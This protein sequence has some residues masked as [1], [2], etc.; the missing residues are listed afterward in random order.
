MQ[1]LHF[2]ME[3]F[4]KSPNFN[5]SVGEIDNPN[6]KLYIYEA[7]EDFSKS[8]NIEDNIRSYMLRGTA[9]SVLGDNY[10]YDFMKACELGESAAC[11]MYYGNCKWK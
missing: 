3:L 7:I 2:G 8:I 10:C 9:R 6:I 11:E 1:N 5:G 4:S